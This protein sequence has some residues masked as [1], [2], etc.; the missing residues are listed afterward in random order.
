MYPRRPGN[1][2]RFFDVT[3]TAGCP[4]LVA[5]VAGEQSRLMTENP[6]R[7]VERAQAVLVEMFPDSYRPPS[8]THITNWRHD[9][10]SLGIYSMVGF[11]TQAVHFDMLAEPVDGRLLFAGEATNWRHFG[12]VHGAMASGIREARRILG[13]A[14]DLSLP[15]L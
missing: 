13:I 4:M 5:L 11:D 9:P 6:T 10:F 14:A 7:A 12:Y 15:T 2:P 8:D 1:S 3:D